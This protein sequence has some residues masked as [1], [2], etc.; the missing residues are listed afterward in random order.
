[1]INQNKQIEF[2]NQRCLKLLEVQSQEDVLRIVNQAYRQSQSLQEVIL[3]PGKQEM[4]FLDDF[5]S[6]HVNYPLHRSEDVENNGN[7]DLTL[8]FAYKLNYEFK[9]KN[10]KIKKIRIKIITSIQN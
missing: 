6:Q 1:M 8:E 4:S 7:S 5:L 3:L 9:S 2:I 10:S